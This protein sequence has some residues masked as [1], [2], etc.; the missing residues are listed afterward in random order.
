MYVSRVTARDSGHVRSR[1]GGA[2]EEVYCCAPRLKRTET[3]RGPGRMHFQIL[4]RNSDGR[5]SNIVKVGEPSIGACGVDEGSSKLRGRL[6][7][8]AS[9]KW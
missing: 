2:V 1:I 5:F 7:F 4:M 8:E 9:Q 6:G 3:T